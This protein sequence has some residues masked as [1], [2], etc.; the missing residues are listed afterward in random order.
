MRHTKNAIA[1]TSVPFHGDSSEAVQH[2]GRIMVSFR[3]VCDSLGVDY[4]TQHRKIQ[5]RAWA[6]MVI[7]TMRE[8]QILIQKSFMVE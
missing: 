5:E 4:K 7:M 3:R 6:H 2:K 1:V 8:T